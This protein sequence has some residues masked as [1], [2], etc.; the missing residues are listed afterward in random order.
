MTSARKKTKKTPQKKTARRARTGRKESS[1]RRS[2][3]RWLRWF[4]PGLAIGLGLP[5]LIY[6]NRL[7]EAEFIQHHWV[8][9]SQVYAAPLIA[10]ENAP[11]SPRRLAFHLQQL[12]YR[13]VSASP[14][15]GEYTRTDQGTRSQWQIHTRGF[16]FPAG[17]VPAQRVRLTLQ[18]S[19]AAGGQWRVSQLRGS[20]LLQLEPV[21][22]GGFYSARLEQRQ[23]VA[24]TELPTTLLQG[25]QAVEDRDFKNHH[26]INLGGIARAAWRNLLAGHVVQGG[27]TITQQLVKNRLRASQRSW[28][29]KINEAMLA[30]LLENRLDK[31]RILQDYLNEVYW[32]QAGKVAIHGIAQAADYYFATAPERLDLAQQALLIGLIKGPSWYNPRKHPERARQRRNLVLR[33]MAD[34]GIISEAQR[35]QAAARPLAVTPRGRLHSGAYAD[36]MQ[37]VRQR[38]QQR[39]RPQQLQQAGLRIFTTLD[40]WAQQQ[41]SDS[42]A[43]KVPQIQPSLQAAAVLTRRLSGEI[44]ALDGGIERFSG[45][46]RALLA[47]RQIGSLIKPFIYLAGLELLPDFSLDS[48]LP[49][50]PVAIRTRRGETWQ[51]RNFSQQ[52]HGDVSAADALKHSWNLATVHLGQR[53]G[54][55]RLAQFLNRLGLHTP[56]RLHP[57]LLLGAVE[58][59]PLETSQLY[60]LL[61]SGGAQNE[62]IALRAVT[63]ASGRVLLRPKT[64][65]PPP[66]NAAHVRQIQRV[67]NEITESGTAASLRQWPQL[68]R[69]LFG[70]TGTT[71]GGRDNWFAGFDRRYLLTVWVGRDDNRPTGLTG[72][73]AALPVWADAMQK[74]QETR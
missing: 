70:K 65:T 1:L 20:E 57:S 25:L 49:D 31:G 71:N 46:N 16:D 37:L 45:F 32:G 55:K 18:K 74:L 60:Q 39:F 38:L 67:L 2:A 40:P 24:L 68:L 19:N 26:G 10:F 54:L 58:L 48:L 7:V 22:L 63:D 62:T 69:P 50:Q 35:A 42:L 61:A 36:F 8:Q 21:R 53:I 64:A 59:S 9:P 33:L 29:R 12:G 4:L 17:S 41:L 43:A 47:R 44:L 34:T 15:A 11:L 3:L 56:A 14:R 5:W 66:L 28:L 6:L 13:P 27:S 72:A 52:S 73:R 30:L 51:P 23:P